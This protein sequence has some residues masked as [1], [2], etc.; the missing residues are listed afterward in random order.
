[1]KLRLSGHVG[2]V[3]TTAFSPDGR[4]VL[5]VAA[6]AGGQPGEARL[7]ES[8]TGRLL[9]APPLRHGRGDIHHAAFSPDGKLLVTAGADG[10]SR[11]W[12]TASGRPAGEPLRHPGPVWH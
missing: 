1:E 11:L 3:R 10:T 6:G 7:W 8:A 5:T 12:D 2:P 9:T 4:L